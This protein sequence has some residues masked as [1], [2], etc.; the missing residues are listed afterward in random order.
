MSAE[1]NDGSMLTL[2]PNRASGGFKVFKLAESNFKVWDAD[3][4]HDAQN[5]EH[6][7]EMHVDHLRD[8]RSAAD[9]L[10]EI[11][12]KSGFPLTAPSRSWLWVA[13]VFSA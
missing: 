9:F 12:L 3:K 8:G 11:L 1:F 5:L 10:Y 13:S 6:Q 7:L 2:G 4:S